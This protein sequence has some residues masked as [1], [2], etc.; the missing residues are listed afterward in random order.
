MGREKNAYDSS[1]EKPLDALHNTRRILLDKGSGL[2]KNIRQRERF[3]CCL[4]RKIFLN[5]NTIK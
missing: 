3:R 5:H 4:G 1:Q 2:P